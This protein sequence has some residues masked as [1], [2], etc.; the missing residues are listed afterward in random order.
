MT[1]EHFDCLPAR[2]A[3]VED[4]C[5]F[6]IIVTF[7]LLA[8]QPVPITVRDCLLRSGYSSGVPETPITSLAGVDA[9]AGGFGELVLRDGARIGTAYLDDS[10]GA[11]RMLSFHVYAGAV[12]VFVYKHPDDPGRRLPGDPPGTWHGDCLLRVAG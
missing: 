12:F 5:M 4:I 6:A 7:V 2:L 11:R 10:D 8:F 3:L 1:P 9:W